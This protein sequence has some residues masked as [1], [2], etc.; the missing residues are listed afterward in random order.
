MPLID[1]Y[2]WQFDGACNDADSSIFFSPETERGKKRAGRE[3][4]AKAYCARCPVV[5]EC[6]EHA[7]TVR[8]PFGV[9]GGLN[10]SERN[11]LLTRGT[12][13]RAS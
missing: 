6:L 2:A 7:L 1:E 10:T 5:K 9:W 8:E 11:A 3:A 4:E 13:R 12:S